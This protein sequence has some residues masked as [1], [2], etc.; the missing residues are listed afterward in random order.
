MKCKLGSLISLLL[1][2]TPWTIGVKQATAATTIELPSVS[3]KPLSLESMPPAMIMLILGRDHTLYNAAYNDLV[4]LNGNSKL[5]IDDT[6]FNPSV[7][8]YG[9]FDSYK[10]YSYSVA[11][12]V[13]DSKFVPQQYISGALKDTDCGGTQWSG[14]F[15]N[16]LTTSRMDALRKALY[17]GYRISDPSTG[18]ATLQASFMPA[19]SHVWGKAYYP[20][21]D[22]LYNSNFLIKKFAPYENDQKLF[23]ARI[24][25][26]ASDSPGSGNITAPELR[27]L[28]LTKVKA[29][30][31]L[32]DNDYNQMTVSH[33]AGTGTPEART[34]LIKPTSSSGEIYLLKEKIS[35]KDNNDTGKSHAYYFPDLNGGPQN[36]DID[37]LKKFVINVDVCNNN[38]TFKYEDSSNNHGNKEGCSAY[39]NGSTTVYKP[40]G[41]LH[42]YA[43]NKKAEFGLITGSYDV[44]LDGGV[45]RRN[46]A[47]FSKE[48]DSATGVFNYSQTGGVK[49]IV[50]NLNTL[51]IINFDMDP[52]V[53][54]Q[55]NPWSYYDGYSYT[56]C[57]L[58]NKAL[59]TNGTCTN[60]GNPIGEMLAEA[61]NYF[62]QH[63][64]KTPNSNYNTSNTKDAALGL[65]NENWLDPYADTTLTMD[66][67][68]RPY[69]TPAF[70]LIV[71]NNNVSYDGDTISNAF[72]PTGTKKTSWSDWT[73]VIG[74]K[75]KL[76]GKSYFMGSNGTLDD[77][78]P[79]A[80]TLGKL[81]NVRGM[82]T[83]PTRGGSY[84]S[85]GIAYFGNMTNIFSGKSKPSTVKT[86]ALSLA[87]PLPE[88]TI[89]TGANK[90]HTIA[91]IPFAKSVKK[92]KNSKGI[93]QIPNGSPDEDNKIHPTGSFQPTN[94]IVNFYAEE[95]NDSYGRF[96]VSFSDTE[97]GFDYDMDMVATYEYK[98]TA[99]NKVQI[100]VTSNYASGDIEQHAGYI[101][102]GTTEDKLYLVVRDMPDCNKDDSAAHTFNYEQTTNYAADT[103][104]PLKPIVTGQN[105]TDQCFYDT[106]KTDYNSYTKTFTPSDSNAGYYLKPPLW[107]A[108]K[109]GFY[110]N[111]P[112]AAV[113]GTIDDAT[114]VQTN[115][116]ATPDGYF[117]VTNTNMLTS[118]LNK[119][120]TS[121]DPNSYTAS[122]L[123]TSDYVLTSNSIQYSSYYIPL[124]WQGDVVAKSIAADGTVASTPLWSAAIKLGNMAT[125]D[126]KIY[127]YDPDSKKAIIF[128]KSSLTDKQLK[129]LASAANGST[130]GSDDQLALG[131][132]LVDY[133][134][135]DHTYESVVEP[136]LKTLLRARGSISVTD[137]NGANTAQSVLGDIVNSTPTYGVTINNQAFVA[138]AAN[139]G[140]L[141]I[142]D[143]SSGTNGGKEKFAYIPSDLLLTSETDTLGRKNLG[144]YASTNYGH[145]YFMDGNSSVGKV[146]G[147]TMLIGSM[148]F[149]GRA[150]Y[151]LD[152]SDLDNLGT[153]SVKWEFTSDQMGFNRAPPAI[154]K[155]KLS[156]VDTKV[157]IFSNGYNAPALSAKGSC[158][159]YPCGTLFIRKA[160]D[161]SL[162]K[163]IRTTVMSGLSEPAVIDKDG[164][165]YADTVYAGDLKGNL[166]KMDI[167]DTDSAKWSDIA[168]NI[169]TTTTGQ[170]ITTKPAV[171][172]N[173]TRGVMIYFGTG[174]YLE[175]PD[176]VA[177]NQTTSQA[178]Y[179][180]WDDPQ[181][182]QYPILSTKL[183]AQTVV[184]KNTDTRYITGNAIP[185]WNTQRGWYFLLPTQ[186]ERVTVNPELVLGKLNMVTMI[187]GNDKENCVG[188][189]TGWLMQ[190]NAQ[191]GIA[192]Y[193]NTDAQKQS[194][195]IHLGSIGSSFNSNIVSTGSSGSTLG[196][197]SQTQGH[198]KTQ[199]TVQNPTVK[200]G[201]MS[202]K[203]LY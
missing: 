174:K 78:L 31:W 116:D 91:L 133:M 145:R 97:Q 194:S 74:A 59:S 75:E 94:P 73:D 61:M 36:Y 13:G 53:N 54:T 195:N 120:L 32:S 201:M 110:N 64:A 141:H 67:Q 8:Y 121:T 127:T 29:K 81:S 12:S 82:L 98:V 139:D 159:D 28:N 65:T 50:Y 100:T 131:K 149:G 79:T 169:F 188:G 77:G 173:S 138:A 72:I 60:W 191:A 155:M 3:N 136:T 43:K 25:E 18:G 5:D 158:G 37:T 132:N 106:S 146:D 23:F 47:D 181:N 38:T 119:A 168:T 140:M 118:Q 157:V 88:I 89:K 15:L 22:P 103:Y 16:Y 161:G 150:V 137:K 172:S 83:E 58:W 11:P 99:D 35:F 52:K 49:G 108:A 166:W 184:Q 153:S 44:N 180:L 178:F 124:N 111:A 164:D 196:G 152:L 135:G 34:Y 56:D 115:A 45:L 62:Y 199:T 143:A 170:P 92:W 19:D 17:G 51:K 147:T 70:N 160:A 14:N 33:W 48:Y 10:C 46:M 107:Y 165:G 39:K 156:G 129:A 177:S 134:R 189:G 57:S 101:I 183:L 171:G 193:S 93:W 200:A 95:I 71:S 197:Q 27:V 9:Y 113:G 163:T 84:S 42:T 66:G 87:P 40:E 185:D 176:A 142:F 26:T 167:S 192:Y 105:G 203:Q 187:P 144:E 76:E 162:I 123:R 69:C 202:W 90:D 41:I 154:V 30:T 4:D 63:T 55:K 179:G 198:D 7:E 80:K 24:N 128:D 122:A 190:I 186:G 112:S 126:R 1:I 182:T 125:S 104:T 2:T 130:L 117:S 96:K 20:S 21:G 68:T 6:R 109:W 175:T 114:T 102:S 86:M 151:A 148:G 85:S